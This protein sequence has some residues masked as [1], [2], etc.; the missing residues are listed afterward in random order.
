[1]TFLSG[2]FFVKQTAIRGPVARRSDAGTPR[3]TAGFAVGFGFALMFALACA[4]PARVA[5]EA[6]G[7]EGLASYYANSLAGR[8]TASGEPYDPRA[9]TAAHRTLPFGSV[10]RVER[11]GANGRAA[12][13]RFVE[14]RI[15][16]RGPFVEGRIIDLS[17]AA[18][19]ELGIGREG[20][21]RVRV[22]VIEPASR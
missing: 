11:I 21:V 10:V 6:P 5:P 2:E 12:G 4:S 7:Q 3:R 9:F 17:S 8:P 19:D 13:D 20:V 16:D 22:R 1:M 14:V 18:A 15:N